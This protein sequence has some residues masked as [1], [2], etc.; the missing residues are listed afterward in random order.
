M[1]VHLGGLR[2]EVSPLKQR[3]DV[4]KGVVGFTTRDL[5]LFGGLSQRLEVDEVQNRFFS[6]TLDGASLG[7]EGRCGIQEGRFL[8]RQVVHGRCHIV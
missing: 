7:G 8:Y 4:C 2:A 3:F 6:E 5:V 1:H